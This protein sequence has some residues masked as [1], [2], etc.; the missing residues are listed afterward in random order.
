MNRDVV[1]QLIHTLVCIYIYIEYV[2]FVHMDSHP[3]CQAQ[4]YFW[5]RSPAF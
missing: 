2:D 4:A 5:L 1:N 3:S